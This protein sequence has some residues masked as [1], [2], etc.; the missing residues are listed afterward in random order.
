MSGT[1]FFERDVRIEGKVVIRASARK[2]L[3]DSGRDGPQGWDVSL[4]KQSG[5]ISLTLI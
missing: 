5:A 4:K 2:G 3:P 1:V